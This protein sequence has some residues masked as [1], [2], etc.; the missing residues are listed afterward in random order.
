MPDAF[1]GSTDSEIPLSAFPF[2]LLSH[3]P[4]SF[5]IES[6]ALCQKSDTSCKSLSLSSFS[7]GWEESLSLLL[8]PPLL[9]QQYALKVL[10]T[11]K[12]QKRCNS[13]ETNLVLKHSVANC[14]VSNDHH[15]DFLPVLCCMY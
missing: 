3:S 5:P 13:S 6:P 11:L 9:R 10:C 1:G 2:Q 14:N 7:A 4:N 8:P 12:Q 15:F